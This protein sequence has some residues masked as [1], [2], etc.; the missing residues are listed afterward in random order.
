MK[1][2]I[3][4][5]I[6]LL[7]ILFTTCSDAP[8]NVD[9]TWAKENKIMVKLS[10]PVQKV[11]KVTATVR[12]ESSYQFTLHNTGESGDLSAQDSIWTYQFESYYGAPPGQ[13]HLD[14]SVV[15][16]QGNEVVTPGNE[17]RYLGRSGTIIVEVPAE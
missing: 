12:E 16:H 3:F 17:H 15:D 9:Q 6:I 4:T 8:I 11:D 7:N 13:Y 2:L 1:K 10:G 14:I 5:A